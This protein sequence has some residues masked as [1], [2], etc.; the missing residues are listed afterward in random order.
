VLRVLR[1]QREQGRAREQPQRALQPMLDASQRQAG[2]AHERG[3]QRAALGV[4]AGQQARAR[5]FDHLRP[6]LHGALAQRPRAQ[7]QA[8]TQVA[9]F[10]GGRH[11]RA[12]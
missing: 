10:A 12:A 2:A 9:Q 1:V 4:F 6:R 7:P 11:G 3:P 8:G 5:R